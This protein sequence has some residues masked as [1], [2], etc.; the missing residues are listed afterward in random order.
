MRIIFKRKFVRCPEL[1]SFRVSFFVVAVSIP[2][3]ITF[4]N[5]V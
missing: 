3:E 4:T 1:L 5:D 2:G